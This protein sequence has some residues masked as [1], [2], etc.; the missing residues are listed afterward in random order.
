[1]KLTKYQIIKVK[2]DSAGQSVKFSA[3]TDKLYQKVQGIYVSL[4]K[5]TSHFGSSLELRISEQE[6]FPEGFET[7][8]LAANQSSSPNER[9]AM[10]DKDE[11]IEAKG[12]H[13]EGRFVD[14]GFDDGSTFPYTMN[15][16][17]K[18]KNE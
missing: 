7:K 13:M 5:D 8:L 11:V 1:M 18:L 3:E 9:F 14:G 4:P 10:F 17:L 6:I 12:S 16:Y 2:V 15:I